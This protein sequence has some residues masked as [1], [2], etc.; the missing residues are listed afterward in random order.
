[1]NG[2][3]WTKVITLYKGMKMKNIEKYYKLLWSHDLYLRI[4]EKLLLRI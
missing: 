1:M 2:K 3:K 4:N